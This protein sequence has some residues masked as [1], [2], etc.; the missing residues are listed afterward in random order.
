MALKKITAHLSVPSQGLMLAG[1]AL[2]AVA[3]LQL[4]FSASALAS[5]RV[6]WQSVATTGEV[7]SPA[8]VVER[9]LPADVDDANWEPVQNVGR[10]ISEL[11][12]KLSKRYRLAGTF[13]MYTTQG[14]YFRKA[15]LDDL[16]KNS[17]ITVIEG[18][19][20]DEFKV[21]RILRD[22][23]VVSDEAG[24]ELE[25]WQSVG[26]TGSDGPLDTIAKESGLDQAALKA[27]GGK[28]TGDNRWSFERSALL[29][30][31]QTLRE[32]PDRLVRV[33]DSMKPVYDKEN[34][35][36]GYQVG[37]EGERELF[38]AFGLRDGDTIRT[39]NDVR[40][41]NRRRAEFFIKQFALGR[42]TA[43]VIDVERGGAVD[44]R[45]Y[46]IK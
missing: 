32:N 9:P 46:Q 7:Y 16:A 5:I 21:V 35:I 13:F 25:I 26:G 19:A 24:R 10:D 17:Q 42:N 6:S 4:A 14:S 2:I 31:Y 33:F 27:F 30:Y 15:I 3:L 11:Q 36:N 8:I 43:F 45:F 22:R 23:V 40:M 38:S 29:R 44:K 20:L 28:Y 39:V 12:G 18:N 37:I 41:T 1:A 34:R